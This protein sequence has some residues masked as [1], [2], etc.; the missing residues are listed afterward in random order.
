[1]K[2]QRTLLIL[3]IMIMTSLA[4][5]QENKQ[6]NSGFFQFGKRDS[7]KKHFI[8]S[9]G[10]I[11]VN[12]I[13]DQS[14]PP[15]FFQLNYGYWFTD[16]DVVS[17]EAIT[18]KYRFPLGIPMGSSSFEAEGEDYPGYIRGTGI[19]IAYQ[20]YIWKDLYLGLHALSLV[21]NFENIETDKDQ[22]GYQLFCTFRIG[23]HIR[24]NDR[25]FIEPSI[26][27]TTWPINTNIPEAFEDVENKWN[28][29][30]F[31]PGLHFGFK[32]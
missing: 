26:A 20:R 31:E 7:N 4:L 6:S 2:L 21:Q 23:Y 3:I 17:V 28:K 22:Y 30:A 19:G 24:L 10:F 14:N 1:M 12:L 27:T 8:G 5:S 9:S 11:L 15:D 16:N 29:F 13:P 32:F 18:W 25:W